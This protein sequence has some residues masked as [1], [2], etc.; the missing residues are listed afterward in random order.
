MDHDAIALG[1]EFVKLLMVVRKR[2]PGAFDHGVD[3]LVSLAKRVRAIVRHEIRGVKLRDAIDAAPVPDHLGD[4]TNQ[5]LVFLA[6]T[7]APVSAAERSVS[8]AARSAGR[9]ILLF[10]ASGWV[11]RWC[12]IASPHPLAQDDR[13]RSRRVAETW[14]RCQ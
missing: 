14:G 8:A 4:F 11:A 1:N 5:L 12:V 6:H 9:W 3:A 7:L 13:S 2:G 10:G